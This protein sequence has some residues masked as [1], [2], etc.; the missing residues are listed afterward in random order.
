MYNIDLHRENVTQIT[1]NLIIDN[2]YNKKQ[3]NQPYPKYVH[4]TFKPGLHMIA[5]I[6]TIA[7]TMIAII[8]RAARV[9]SI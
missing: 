2:G 8:A 6:A 7:V 3:T 5:M 9:V 1:D 4:L